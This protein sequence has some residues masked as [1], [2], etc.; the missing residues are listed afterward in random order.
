MKK[1]IFRVLFVCGC[2]LGLLGAAAETPSAKKLEPTLELLVS[3]TNLVVTE[4]MTVGLRL[5]LPPLEDALADTPPVL[6]QEPPHFQVPF[7]M[8]DQPEGPLVP[9]DERQMPPID[10]K[11]GRGRNTGTFTLNDFVTDGFDSLRDPFGGRDPF[12]S[13][14]DGDDFFGRTLGPRPARFPCALVR[15]PRGE[16]NGWLLTITSIPYRAQRAGKVEF[17]AVHATVPIVTDVRVTRDRFGRATYAPS[18]KKV[19]LQA[20]ACTVEV[21]EPPL[22]GRPASYCGA[23]A[24]NLV[25]QATLDTNICTAGDPLVLTLDISGAA[26]LSAVVAPSFAAQFK[27]DGVFRL[28]EASLKT[29]TLA[30]SR[31]FTWRVRPL[32]AGTVEFPSLP[33]AYYDLDRRAYVT[34]RTESIP[35]QVKAGVQAA[36]GAIDEA[37][38]ADVFPAPDGLDLDPKG[39]DVEP[40]LPHLTWVLVLFMLPPMLFVLIR[41]TPP[42][43]RR[44]AAQRAAARRATAYK[45]CAR[46]LKGRD[47]SR[48]TAAIRTFFETR[49]GVNGATV[50]AADARRLMVDDYSPDE[51]EAV[52]SA[53]AEADRTNYA[54]RKVVVSLLLVCLA[55]FG[56]CGASPAFTYRRA[57]ALAL[58]AVDEKGFKTAAKA[59][60]EAIEEGAQNATVYANLGACALMGGDHKTALAAFACAERRAGETATT[61]RGVRAAWTRLKADPRADLPLTRSFCAPH[62]RFPVDVRLLFAAVLWALF[63]GVL[64]L[65]AG[66]LRQFLVTVCV[67]A[68]LASAGSATVSLVGEQMAKGVIH[69]VR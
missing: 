57:G 50:T 52:A 39:A 15:A 47:P 5:W 25:V 35:L 46:A 66:T 54:A 43:R 48:R 30:A 3:A 64:L 40:L 1:F 62:V 9:V 34:V 8:P 58:Q 14:L 29:E 31:R 36:L 65:P 17:G 63:W 27:Q 11:G 59:Y 22:A 21:V 19:K 26:D 4:E 24:S 45:V 60:A 41:L 56:A 42:V 67:L 6:R 7:W 32:K 18:F 69:A 68:F 53:L 10:M 44:V 23:L 28:D 2:L 51:I 20:P 37:D 16:V 55:A 49:Y 38:E 12:G 61:R 13:L 33:V